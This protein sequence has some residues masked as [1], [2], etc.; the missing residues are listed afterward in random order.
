ML[1]MNC[2]V[3]CQDALKRSERKRRPENA[4]TRIF[5]AR[6]ANSLYHWHDGSKSAIVVCFF[7]LFT[8]VDQTFRLYAPFRERIRG[9]SFILAKCRICENL[10]WQSFCHIDVE[11]QLKGWASGS[12]WRIDWCIAGQWRLT[13]L[14]RQQQRRLDRQQNRRRC[15]QCS[16]SWAHLQAELRP[17]LWGWRSAPRVRSHVWRGRQ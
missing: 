9:A 14:F 1:M 17:W 13:E 5:K 10:T 7:L 4:Y 11:N 16:R 2:C 8:Q 15:F 6:L 12:R 3:S